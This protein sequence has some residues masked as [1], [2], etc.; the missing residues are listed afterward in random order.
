MTGYNN[1]IFSPLGSEPLPSADNDNTG[2]YPESGRDISLLNSPEPSELPALENPEAG[3]EDSSIMFMPPRRKHSTANIASM[4]QEVSAK[5]DEPA[6]LDDLLQVVRSGQDLSPGEA[7]SLARSV[8]TRL[9]DDIKQQLPTAFTDIDFGIVDQWSYLKDNPKS[10]DILGDPAFQRLLGSKAQYISNLERLYYSSPIGAGWLGFKRG[11]RNAQF[12]YLG[13]HNRDKYADPDFQSKAFSL[14]MKRAEDQDFLER[15]EQGSGFIGNLWREFQVNA[16]DT[17]GGMAFSGL[18]PEALGLGGAGA[19]AGGL[20]APVTGLGSWLTGLSLAQ[21]EI[22]GGANALEFYL[23]QPDEMKDM[24]L[25]NRLYYMTMVPSLITE[26][27][28]NR[29]LIGGAGAGLKQAVHG[30]GKVAAPGLTSQIDDLLVSPTYKGVVARLFANATGH[31]APEII[32]EGLQEGPIEAGS[33]MLATRMYNMA[34]NQRGYFMQEPGW[35][36]VVD[37]ALAGAWQAFWGGAAIGGIGP[38]V[39]AIRDAAEVSRLRSGPAGSVHAV[40]P[41]A[42]AL[43]PSQQEAIIDYGID[44][45]ERRLHLTTVEKANADVRQRAKVAADN[46]KEILSDPILASNPDVVHD[47]LDRLGEN[48]A[49]ANAETLSQLFQPSMGNSQLDALGNGGIEV[50][51]ALGV[52][53]EQFINALD[54]G[55]DVL[56]DLNGLPEVVNNPLWD[57]IAE[58]I[59]VEPFGITED[60]RSDLYNMPPPP[61]IID[62]ANAD[63]SPQVMTALEQKLIAAGRKQG[64]ARREA[65]VWSRMAGNLARITG[66]KADAVV[67]S[68]AFVNSVDANKGTAIQSLNQP[69]NT[70]LDLNREVEA[71][72]ARVTDLERKVH[73]LTKGQGRVNLRKSIVGTYRNLDQGWNIVLNRVGADHAISSALNSA[74]PNA[75]L[76]AVASLPDLIKNSVLVETHADRK[77]QRGLKNVHRFFAPLDINDSIFSVKLTVKE[78]ENGVN[79][80]DIE[81]ITK[82]YDLK[83]EK[84]MPGGIRLGHTSKRTSKLGSGSAPSIYNINIAQLIKDVN[85]SEGQIYLQGQ[86]EN[87][88]RGRTD[89]LPD[90]LARIIFSPEADAS[91]AIHEFQHA[92]IRQ[93]QQI[94]SMPLDQIADLDLRNQLE[95]DMKT[96]EEW[97]GIKEGQWTV[98]AHEKVARGFEQYFMEGKAPVKSLQRI[99]GQMKRWLMNIYKSLRDLGEPLSDDVRRVFDRQLATDEELMVESWRGEPA[100]SQDEFSGKVDPQAWAEYETAVAKGREAAGEEIINFRNAEHERLIKQWQREGR[101]AAN[102]DP[103]QMRLKEIKQ[104]GGIN[105]ASLKAGGYDSAAIAAL[106]RKRPGLVTDKGTGGFDE[107]AERYGFEYSDDF[108]QE[109]INTP[110]IKELT[111]VYV[112]EQE[113]LF[114]RY[115]DSES[116]ITDAELDAWEQERDLWARFMGDAGSKYQRRSWRDIKRVIDRNTGLK[117]VDEIAAQNMA[118]LRASLKVQ[119][120]AARQG[121]AE[122]EQAG[123]AKGYKRGAVEGYYAGRN[124]ARAEALDKRLELAAKLKS[125]TERQREI[126]KTVAGWRKLIKQKTAEQYKHGGILPAYHGQIKNLLAQFGI[127]SEVNTETDFNTFISRLEEDGAPL[128][129]PDWIRNGQWPMWEN[130]ARAGQRKTYKGLNYSQ[131]TELKNAIANL[132]FL[133]KRQQQVLVDG[134]L[135]S[136][137]NAANR[138]VDSIA[139]ENEIAPLKSQAELLEEAGNK[140]SLGAALVEGLSGYMSSIIKTETMARR[141]DGG[142]Y[143]GLAQKLVYKPVNAAYEK[144]MALSE[145]LIQNKLKSLVERTV[146]AKAI[147]KW[148]SEKVLIEVAGDSSQN[149]NLTREQMILMALND[150]NEQNRKALRNYQ[151]GPNGE[152]MTDLQMQS[153]RDA[154]S[155]SEW[156]FVQELWD[157]MDNDIF[158]LLNDLTM[159]TKGVPLTKVEASPVYTKYGVM[160]GGYFPLKFDAA[161]SEKADR[162]RDSAEVVR[163]TPGLYARPNT[164]ASAT[165]ERSGRTYN[166]LVPLLSFDV[167]TS[168]I[169]D[170]IHDLTHRQAVNDVWRIIKRP[171]VRRAIE[172]SLGGNYWVQMKRWLQEVAKPEKIGDA[173]GRSIL[174]TIRGNTSIAAMGLKAS[175]MACQVTGITQ[176][177]HKL[178]AYWTGVGLK[179]FYKNP[180]AAADMMYAKS[181]ALKNRNT[182]SYDRDIHDVIAS[183]N[184]LARQLKDKWADVAFKPIAFLDQA[185]ANPVWLGAYLKAIK[186]DGK[187]EADAVYYADAIVRTTQPTG[188]IK[189][190]SRAQRGWGYGDA[191][192]L[193]TMFSTFFNGTQNL[194]WEQFHETK[195]DF[196]KGEYLKGTYKAGRATILMAV[197]PALMEAL[198]KEGPPEDEEDLIDLGKGVVSYTVGGLPVV[199]DAVSYWLGDSFRFRPAPVIDSVES[200][201]KAPGGIMDIAEGDTAK[202]VNRLLRGL[203]PLTGIP[204]GQLGA[205]IKGIEDWDDNQGFE[206][207]YRLFI[208]ESPK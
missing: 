136:E 204:S 70:G 47:V 108:I 123:K 97:A 44:V 96:L 200:I 33:Q 9:P 41:K 148:R 143:D 133:G 185:V 178:G 84:E 155:K 77:N 2:Y 179:E 8:G 60:I 165:I 192:K 101:S 21:A 141:L 22:A 150:G 6:T 125:A 107:F 83:I 130:G 71:V 190:M 113:A 76:I 149:M 57:S 90:G 62:R 197:M 52:S 199:K 37:S 119:A 67:N 117:P 26:T 79:E 24:D 14:M 159:K 186:A 5:R 112:S 20:G 174:R 35:D 188:A 146:G 91:T 82:L 137:E 69:Y 72:S 118:D 208:R 23:N 160:R 135:M 59:T 42:V 173:G 38:G 110:T 115:F 189:D 126:E 122:G 61:I 3:R 206:A 29:F 36:D 134:H 16:G 195:A 53:A 45:A 109:L 75:H 120:R 201:L 13:A 158:P 98:E 30:A 99:F 50:L 15:L 153:V 28:G 172:G 63:V 145:D 187:S 163:N 128:A 46:I 169:N 182:T 194:I 105:R 142:K 86:D 85:D 196:K 51:G 171:E 39:E 17:I 152:P 116:I 94:L 203:G 40:T 65:Q 31:M 73:E 175:V 207:V 111:D 92:F 64:A 80:V 78:Y 87:N 102:D 100:F 88:F 104:A 176:S 164:Q 147:L 124:E 12:G 48:K 157:F 129:V 81:R 103:R 166:D 121:F 170:N 114:E 56:L 181:P 127:G 49:Y 1:N 154:L 10:R 168:S 193:L 183:R 43:T 74:E 140:K 138:L 161:M 34:Y 131:F 27:V 19:L 7:L 191:G 151:L 18:T 198:I 202:G 95:A 184:P 162:Q 68:V 144:A 11:L 106:Q 205:T 167:L 55:T 139:S 66:A 89:F 180:R 4:N 25:A 93:A 32:T 132:T 156:D 58:I 54:S 177:V